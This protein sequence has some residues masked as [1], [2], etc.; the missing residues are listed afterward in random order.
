MDSTST[1]DVQVK[2]KDKKEKYVANEDGAHA[3]DEN[4]PT[5]KVDLLYL[6]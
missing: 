6:P 4:V 1:L 3:M 5:V 2:T